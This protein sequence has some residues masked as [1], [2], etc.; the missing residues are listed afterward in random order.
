MDGIVEQAQQTSKGNDRNTILL[1]FIR[2]FLSWDRQQYVSKML[3]KFIA[4]PIRDF[5]S[6]KIAR[7]LLK[8][9]LRA[10]YR[11]DS[12]AM[13]LL[14]CYNMCDK[15]IKNTSILNDEE[16]SNVLLEFCP[17]PHW[18]NKIEA[19]I[20]QYRN[21]LQFGIVLLLNDLKRECIFDLEINADYFRC[22]REVRDKSSLIKSLMR[23]IYNEKYNIE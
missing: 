6:N 17:T 23:V 22:M 9:Y 3:N 19:E 14:K 7:K 21:G 20:I 4:M 5:L 13:S 15:L 11:F 16:I 10:T 1:I 12:E 2:V 18:R 8:R